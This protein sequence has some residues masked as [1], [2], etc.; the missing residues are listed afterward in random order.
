MSLRMMANRQGQ[1]KGRNAKGLGLFSTSVFGSTGCLISPS[2][3]SQSHC[4]LHNKL[5]QREVAN[6]ST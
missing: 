4:V 6:L 3:W 2:T 5:G 1:C